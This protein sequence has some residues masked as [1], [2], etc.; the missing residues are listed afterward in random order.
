MKI[1]V[2]GCSHSCNPIDK[3]YSK[4]LNERYGYSVKNISKSGQSNQSII[5]KI[6]DWVNLEKIKDNYIIC[7]LTYT[8]RLG[9]F[10]D[11]LDRWYDYQPY[12]AINIF[13]NEFNE[14]KKNKLSDEIGNDL[15]KFYET[16]LKWIYNSEAEFE[17]LMLSVDMLNEWA[18]SNGNKMVFIYWPNPNKDEPIQLKKRNF[19]NI[20]GNYSMDAVSKH[21]GLQDFDGHLTEDG[22]IFMAEKINDWITKL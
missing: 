13:L 19:F 8:H 22:N 4:Y 14:L 18:K 9:M 21:N 5:K 3:S 1:I 20:D 11:V 7:Q 17:S 15:L 6:Y 12:G 2:S 10:H 16:Y